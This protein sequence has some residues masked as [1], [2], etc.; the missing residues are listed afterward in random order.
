MESL[1]EGRDDDVIGGKTGA[2]RKVG[3][4]LHLQ[5]AEW[6]LFFSLMGN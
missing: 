1:V 5:F 6:T 3:L 4:N 2:G